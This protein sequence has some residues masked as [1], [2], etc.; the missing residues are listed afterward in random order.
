MGKTNR[1]TFDLKLK[2]REKE[3]EHSSDY[4]ELGFL[5][6]SKVHDSTNFGEGKGGRKMGLKF[7]A[8][9]G[10]G[11]SYIREQRIRKGYINFKSGSEFGACRSREFGETWRNAIG[12]QIFEQMS[13]RRQCLFGVAAQVR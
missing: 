2:G 3:K 7:A 11:G 10:S 1:P 4:T 8:M 13:V 5:V 6:I 9:N 12:C